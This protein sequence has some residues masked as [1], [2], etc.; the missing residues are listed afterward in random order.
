MICQAFAEYNAHFSEKEDGKLAVT[1]II[2]RSIPPSH[3]KPQNRTFYIISLNF[4]L[5]VEINMCFDF[6][7][8]IKKL[9]VNFC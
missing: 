3:T 4:S 1:F 7:S 5:Y 6:F 8:L 2:I 9:K